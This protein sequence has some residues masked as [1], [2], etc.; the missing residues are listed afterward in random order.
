MP[1]I[2]FRNTFPLDSDLFS[3]QCYP[4]FEQLGPDKKY[5]YAMD[6]LSTV[7]LVLSGHRI[8]RTPSIER[9]VAEVPKFISLIFFK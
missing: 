7:K 1:I 8:K 2:D 3:G 9:T 5:C 6:I 4:A